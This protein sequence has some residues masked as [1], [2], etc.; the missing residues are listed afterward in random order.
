MLKP[1]GEVRY[2]VCNEMV[3][4]VKLGLLESS[5]MSVRWQG[6]RCDALT[7]RADLTFCLLVFPRPTQRL[8]H[9]SQSKRKRP[10]AADGNTTQGSLCDS[11]P[12]TSSVQPQPFSHQSTALGLQRAPATQEEGQQ[13]I[14]VI[15]PTRLPH[16]QACPS[17]YKPSP[18]P[19]SLK[20][21]PRLTSPK[22]LPFTSLPNQNSSY[23]KS[24]ALCSA[25]K[26]SSLCSL[27][28]QPPGSFTP[29]S[30]SSSTSHVLS[31]SVE[32]SHEL[33]LLTPPKKCTRPVN[34]LK[35]SCGNFQHESFLQPDS[36]ELKKVSSV[37]FL[38]IVALS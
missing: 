19:Y 3:K 29:F 32:S 9:T 38:H 14:S 11:V 31:A 30:H 8:A 36:F 12:L 26:P 35:E 23:L 24:L 2:F 6:C 20:Y 7:A 10:H 15:Q 25:K 13:H 37:F 34:S 18:D 22:H 17:S 1:S 33:S 4:R 5:S 28:N 27:P 16:S 21:M